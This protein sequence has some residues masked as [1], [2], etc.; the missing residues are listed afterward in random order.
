[1]SLRTFLACLWT[2]V[3]TLLALSMVTMIGI[4]IS[5]TYTKRI[6]QSAQGLD[7]YTPDESTD[8]TSTS[9]G[10]ADKNYRLKSHIFA[11]IEK[12]NE[13]KE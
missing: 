4:A 8:A 12:K 1:M 2:T 10:G 13:R 7:Q 6:Q 3:V 9:R 5:V 11:V